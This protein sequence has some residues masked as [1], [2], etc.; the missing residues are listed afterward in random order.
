MCGLAGQTMLAPKVMY[1]CVNK[2][3][4]QWHVGV[5]GWDKEEKQSSWSKGISETNL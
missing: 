2:W 3:K 4:H 5:Y 1:K